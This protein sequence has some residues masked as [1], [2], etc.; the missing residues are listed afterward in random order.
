MMKQVFRLTVCVFGL[1]LL[2]SQ[3]FA[4]AL[5][6]EGRGFVNVNF[7]MQIKGTQ[8]VTAEDSFPIYDESAKITSAQTI[9]SQAPFIDFGGG[10][11]VFGNFGAGFAYSRL[12]TNG[13]AAVTASVPSPLVYDQPRTATAS[14]PDLTHVEQAYHFQAIWMLPIT[15]TLD[16]MFSGGPSVFRLEQGTVL[17]PTVAEVGPPYAAVNL[18]TAT[19]I[20]TGSRLGFN[21][22]ADVSFRFTKMIGVGAMVRY[23]ASTFDLKPEGGSP[24]EVKV[25][26]IQIGGGL[27]IRF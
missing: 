24:L 1:T 20:T 8:L 19:A 6:W 7:G 9:D 27:R 17:T 25:G 12:S 26:G 13:P 15:D 5:P 2:S 4:Q 18:T 11:R 16:V 10:A 3:A 21:V 14:I 22:G 23:A